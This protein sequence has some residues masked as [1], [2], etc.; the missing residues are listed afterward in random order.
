MPRPRGSSD[1]RRRV[2]NPDDLT[3]EIRDRLDQARYRGSAHHKRRPADYGFNPP[4][5]PRPQKS[6]C[7]PKGSPPITWKEAC[8]LFRA[9][10]RRGMVSRRLN[11]KGLPVF[12]WAVDEHNQVYEAKPGEDGHVYHGYMLSKD[13]PQAR[14]ILREWRLRGESSDE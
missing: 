1:P 6:V 10:I 2:I 4:V 13:D 14:H 8:S 9:G 12:V 7:D 11:A 3:P 5:A